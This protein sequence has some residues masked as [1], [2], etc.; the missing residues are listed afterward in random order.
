MKG[1]LGRPDATAAV[2]QDGW[3]L[4]GDI[5]TIDADGFI[6]I[7]DRASRFAKIAGEMVPYAAI[8]NALAPLVG[9]DDAGLPR[10]VVT[11][12]PDPVRG[13]RLVVL[14]NAPPHT[15]DDLRRHLTTAGLPNLFIPSRESFVE[16]DQL[17]VTGSGKL[18]QK[19]IRQ[20]AREATEAQTRP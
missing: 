9:V 5:A 15:G 18:D 19:R 20:L 14:H 13:E 7:I 1:Y 2:I 3:Y 8:E 6:T 17:P 11:S 4:T 16:V 10:V 12:V